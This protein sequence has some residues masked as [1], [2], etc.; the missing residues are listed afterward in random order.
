MATACL[1]TLKANTFHKELLGCEGKLSAAGVKRKHSLIISSKPLWLI[2]T[3]G[4][5]ELGNCPSTIAAVMFDTRT[6]EGLKL[7]SLI[8]LLKG[9]DVSARVRG[10]K[11][12]R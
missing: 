1:I 6:C 5:S 2:G 11:V 12:G 8:P 10:T 9:S 3:V 7:M 4:W